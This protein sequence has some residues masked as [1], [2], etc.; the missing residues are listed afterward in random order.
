MPDEIEGTVVGENE[1]RPPA[2]LVPAPSAGVL[3]PFDV[4]EV[5]DSMEAYQRGL[6]SLLDDS[7]YQDAGDGNR[8][9]KKSGWRK[10]ATWFGLTVEVR[11]Q[12]VERD[13]DGPQRATVI[14]R[15]IAP[16]G[17]AMD[18]DGHCD[19][20][21]PRFRSARARQKL[22]NDLIG[23]AT[24]RAKNRAIA[25]LVGMGDVSAEEVD[26]TPAVPEAGVPASADLLQTARAALDW[27]FDSDQALTANVER[28]VGEAGGVSYV[29]RSAA[30][31]IV[32]VA[33]EL[34]SAQLQDEAL[35]DAVEQGAPDAE[36]ETTNEPKEGTDAESTDDP[37]QVADP[38]DSEA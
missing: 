18:G 35:A 19:R 5:R 33:K 14:A 28:Q 8:F 20:G 34:R 22:E 16:N 31:A 30:Q 13:D 36:P 24:T 11:S 4:R 32:L 38:A 26:S 21:E 29:P 1:T 15:A 3:K 9:V 17:R 27:V 23:T 10:I 7:D 6:K 12:H 25:D 37:S 2:E